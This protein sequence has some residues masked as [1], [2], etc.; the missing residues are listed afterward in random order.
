MVDIETESDEGGMMSQTANNQD[1][2]AGNSTGQPRTRGLS[3]TLWVIQA[4]LA[5]IFLFSGAAKFVLSAEQMKGPVELPVL[6]VRFIGIC[7]VLGALGLIL[8]GLFRI[9]ERLTPLAAA[10][11][12]VIMIGATVVNLIGGL[13]LTALVTV[14]VGLLASFIAYGRWRL[15][16]NRKVSASVIGN[17]GRSVHSIEF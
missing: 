4:V 13:E 5:L 7:E 15:L 2:P 14:I 6:F 11:L 1:R 9:R 17:L 16:S 12:V 3:A 10:G 8:P